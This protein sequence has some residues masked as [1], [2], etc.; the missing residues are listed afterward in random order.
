M[1]PN[2]KKSKL[3]KKKARSKIE[4]KRPH[5]VSSDE[6]ESLAKVK[7]RRKLRK[8]KRLPKTNKVSS[9]DDAA[10]I[11]EQNDVALNEDIIDGFRS[12]CL[13]FIACLMNMYAVS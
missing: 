5:Q 7:K 8:R 9:N 11:K 1:K 12:G 3:R 6:Q 10:P 4:A 2:S 13:N